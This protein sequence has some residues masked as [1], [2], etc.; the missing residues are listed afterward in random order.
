MDL[1]E[2]RYH[3]AARRQGL[4]LH[5]RGEDSWSIGGPPAINPLQPGRHIV[6]SETLISGDRVRLADGRVFRRDMTTAE[7]QEWLGLDDT[8][9]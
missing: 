6:P 2:L 5:R 8:K 4:S 3:E 9:A 1:D 7:L